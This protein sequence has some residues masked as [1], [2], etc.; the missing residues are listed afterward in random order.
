MSERALSVLLVDPSL[1]TAPYDAALDAALG[2][3]GVRTRWAI[4]PPRGGQ[5]REIP[6]ERADE[7]FY[8]RVD[9]ATALPAKLRPVAKGLAHVWGL[10]GLVARVWRRRPD[11]VHFQ[12][13][14]V[15]LLDSIAM[16]AIRWVCP[17]V[18]TVHDTTPYNGE[19]PFFGAVIGIDLPMRLADLVIVHTRAGREALVARGIAAAK[20]RVVAHGPLALQALPAADRPPRDPRWTFLA[21]GE[22]KPY[23]GLD[24]L[25]EATGRLDPEMRAQLRVVM[26]GR[27][28]MDIEPLRAR[29]RELG[30]GGVVE[31]HDRRL[32]EQEMADLFDDTDTFVFPYRQIDAS[33]VFFLV[34]SLGRWMIASRVGIFAEALRVGAEGAGAEGVLVPPEDIA[35]LAEAMADALRQR[36]AAADL[37]ADEGWEAIGRA[38]QQLYRAVARPAAAP[39]A[40]VA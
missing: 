25:V 37:P 39:A 14:V 13:T 10:I 31:L 17:T 16:R 23:K 12:W 6:L 5:P 27:A 18:L 3:A 7:F 33:G 20:I 9:D 19:R 29:I 35:A 32:S 30:L 21:F 22:M 1:F 15:P 28:R 26:A 4:R 34:R 11:V 36:C 24:L 2:A 38:T 8:R 40:E